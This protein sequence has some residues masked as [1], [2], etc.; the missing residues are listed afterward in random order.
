MPKNWKILIFCTI[1]VVKSVSAQEFSSKISTGKGFKSWASLNNF[2]QIAPVYPHFVISPDFYTR[3]LSF[4]CRQEL[5]LEAVTGFPV[6]FRLGSVEYVDWL[7]R[8]PNS[9]LQP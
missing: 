2:R 6:K 1:F 8:K 5:R 3:N 9:R 7:E 4:F